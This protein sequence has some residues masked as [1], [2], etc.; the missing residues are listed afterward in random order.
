[1]SASTK[2]YRPETRLVHA[3]TLRSQFGETSEALFL[4]QGYVYRRAEECEARFSGKIPG[5]VYSRYSNPT[6]SMFEQRMAALEGAEAARSTATGM[7]AVTT[8]LM[9]LVQGRR[10]RGRRQGAVRLLPLG[11]RGMAAALRRDVDVGR[12]HRSRCMAKGGAE[13]YQGVLSGDAD[14]S[15]AGGLSTSPRSRKSRTMPAPS[16]WSTTC[17]PRRS[18]RA[19]SSSAPTAWSIP[20]PST[21]TARAACLGGVILGS[22]KLILDHY[23]QVYAADRAVAVAVQCL[24]AAQGPGDAAGA[25][26]PAD[27]NCRRGRQC[28][29]RPQEDHAADLS[30]T[31]RPSAGRNYPKQMRGGL[32]AL[33]VRSQRRQGRRFPLS[34]RAAS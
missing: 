25:G 31:A 10:P 28:A 5:Y 20:R 29:R 33:L 8:A 12:R 1:M 26:A 2:N 11:D 27:R 18:I 30:G 7:A 32:D 21:S 16:W 9:G 6:M 23:A 3:G 13:K 4:T 17:S 15:D 14:Q 34:Q 24:G 22:E 19:R